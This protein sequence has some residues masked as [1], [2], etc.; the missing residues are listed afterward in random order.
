VRRRWTPE[1]DDVLE[2]LAGSLGITR[3]ATRL[4][5]TVASV[6]SRASLLGISFAP[7]GVFSLNELTQVI[8]TT[9]YRQIRQWVE[10]G[11]LEGTRNRGRGRYGTFQ[12]SEKELVKFLREYAW[13]VDRRKVD[14]AYQ[15]FVGEQW[16]TLAEAFRRGAAHVVS[17]EHGFHAGLIPEARK[18]GN[19]IVVPESIL[20]RLVEGRRLHTTDVEHRRSWTTYAKTQFRRRPIRRQAYHAAKAG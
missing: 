18:R 1:E 16:I 19:R 4:G 8:G 5:R 17:L 14:A 2:S 10:D 3:I 12:V 13:L 15:Q 11:L 7:S 20:P 6:S 9:D